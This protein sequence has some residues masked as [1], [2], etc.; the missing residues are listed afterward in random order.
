MGIDM[1]VAEWPYEGCS[2][3]WQTGTT[4]IVGSPVRCSG[5]E[6][7]RQYAQYEGDT[8][9]ADRGWAG[10]VVHEAVTQPLRRGCC[11]AKK[12]HHA[13]KFQQGMSGR[14]AGSEMLGPFCLYNSVVSLASGGRIFSGMGLEF[15]THVFGL[16][17]AGIHLR[18]GGEFGAM[19]E[20]QVLIVVWITVYEW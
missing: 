19:K 3:D 20:T 5:R 13:A 4:P 17:I 10:T 1:M 7:G 18:G 16:E 14:T 11:Q 8:D 15:R 6:I 2:D 9:P 12:H